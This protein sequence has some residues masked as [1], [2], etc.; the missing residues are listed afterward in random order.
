MIFLP[1]IG[2][3]MA[4]VSMVAGVEEKLSD[5]GY[6]TLFSQDGGPS[7]EFPDKSTYN[8]QKLSR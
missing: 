3:V 1:N 2:R 7:T 4:L 6:Q 8:P 5:L